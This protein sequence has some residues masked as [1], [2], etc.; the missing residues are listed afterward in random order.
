MPE[1]P[2]AYARTVDLV[3]GVQLGASTDDAL[4]EAYERGLRE[5]T[6]GWE[7]EW[8]VDAPEPD[9]DLGLRIVGAG[10]PDEPKSGTRH[11][12]AAD[13]STARLVASWQ[14]GARAVSRLVGPWEPADQPEEAQHG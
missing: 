8:A 6:E 9:D 5:A 10:K 3:D 1:Q 12:F 13:E 2:D 11:S 4:A 14:S 7:R